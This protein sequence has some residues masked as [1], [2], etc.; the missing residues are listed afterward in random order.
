MTESTGGHRFQIGDSV[1]ATVGDQRAQVP[2]VIEA[3]ED[4][5][6]QVSLSQAWVDDQSQ[7]VQ[8]I[9]LSPDRLDPYIGEETGGVE[10]LPG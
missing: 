7:E 4:G 8:D 10:T 5:K 6:F 3:Y 1:L 2:G 9:W